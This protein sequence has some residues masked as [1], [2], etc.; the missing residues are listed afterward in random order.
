MDQLFSG[1]SRPGRAELVMRASSVSLGGPHKLDIFLWNCVSAINVNLS[2]KGIIPY[3][4]TS[5]TTGVHVGTEVLVKA[6]S[7][8][9]APRSQVT[10]APRNQGHG[11]V[12]APKM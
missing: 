11:M 3:P 1:S 4:T 10:M 7:L 8:H 6:T 9:L 5:T 2:V 12:T